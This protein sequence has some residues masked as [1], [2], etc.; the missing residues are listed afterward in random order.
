MIAAVCGLLLGVRPA[1]R[2]L[3][4]IAVICA[5]TALAAYLIAQGY[6]GALPGQHLETWAVLALMMYALASTVASLVALIGPPGM[7]LGALVLVFVGNPFS[8]SSSAPELL[9]KAVAEIG[10]LL[11]PGAGASL[12]RETAYFHG[13]GPVAHLAVL[14]GWSV[15][16]TFGVFVGHH[17]FVG[18]AAR[19]S[20]ASS[21]PVHLAAHAVTGNVGQ[22]QYQPRYQYEGLSQSQGQESVPM[23]EASGMSGMSGMSAASGVSEHIGLL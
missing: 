18:H 4:T 2:Q 9:P 21:H 14:I 11:P 8:G 23:T 1:W 13:H 6:L 16:G 12:L 3:L 10:Q 20:R 22:P 7:G 5:L 19:R 17:S 15:F